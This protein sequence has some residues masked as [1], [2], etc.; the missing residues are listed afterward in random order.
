MYTI[1]VVIL[2]LMV[3]GGGGGYYAH[4]QWGVPGLGG[5]LGLVL[6]VLIIFWLLGG[7]GPRYYGF[8]ISPAYAADV[9]PSVHP[10]G[11]NGNWYGH[12]HKRPCHRGH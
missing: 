3:L 6:I 7:V 8:L 11:F 4:G 2:L 5:V 1:L 12:W 10:G 9:V